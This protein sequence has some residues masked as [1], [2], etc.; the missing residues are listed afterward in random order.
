M[1][2]KS[3]TKQIIY[4]GTLFITVR[5][6]YISALLLTCLRLMKGRA[7]F[8]WPETI[9]AS[10]LHCMVLL[11]KVLFNHAF[12]VF[13]L[14]WL[15]NNYD[16]GLFLPLKRLLWN[17]FV[18]IFT[19]KICTENIVNMKKNPTFRF[20][21]IYV[22]TETLNSHIQLSWWCMYACMSFV[23]WGNIS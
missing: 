9:V 2:K 11:P 10:F 20:W 7:T 17:V 12:I 8:F 3:F 14:H 19:F 23:C 15:W 5:C 16:I 1:H 13:R 18:S 22:I 4:D 6:C 21:R